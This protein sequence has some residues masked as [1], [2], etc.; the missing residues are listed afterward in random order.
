MDNFYVYEWYIVETGE[1]FYVG[2]GTGRR[3]YETL[4]RRNR[5]WENV[6]NRHPCAVRIIHGGLTNDEA[7]QKEIERIAELRKLDQARCNFTNGGT[8]FSTGDLNPNRINPKYGDRNPMRIHGVDFS[9]VHNPF[10]GRHHTT[11]TLAKLSAKLK[12]RPGRRGKA[13]PMYGK[14]FNGKANPMWGRCGFKHPNSKMYRIEHQDGTV[15]TLT[16]KQC[17]SLFGIA[18]LRVKGAGGVLHY[19]RTSPNS[20]YEGDLVIRLK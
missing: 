6:Y 9:G 18:F 3:C 16:S 2:K 4:G 15:E 14:G 12:G 17:E 10:Y 20:I 11:E 5:Y 13:N 7:C 19:K 8:G 1:I